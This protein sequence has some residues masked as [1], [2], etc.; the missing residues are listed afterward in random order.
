MEEE[1]GR[2]ERQ[3]EKRC[4]GAMDRQGRQRRVALHQGQPSE[5]TRGAKA[6]AGKEGLR[7]SVIGRMG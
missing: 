6:E 7:D 4:N 3:A 1:P 5:R 2:R